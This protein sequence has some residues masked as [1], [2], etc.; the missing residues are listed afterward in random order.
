MAA[1]RSQIG[2]RYKAR[3][4]GQRVRANPHAQQLGKLGGRIGGPARAKA[5]SGGQRT[6][7]AKHAANKRW[8]NPSAYQRPPYYRRKPYTQGR[9]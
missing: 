5:L 1:V 2:H 4:V 3:G 9:V 8:K 7:I 6:R